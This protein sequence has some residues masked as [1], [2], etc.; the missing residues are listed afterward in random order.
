MA[1]GF[2]LVALCTL[3]SF[4]IVIALFIFWILVLVEIATKET[5]V[6]NNKLIWLLIVIFTHA[7]GALIYVIVRRPQRIQELG[8]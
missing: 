5:D 8:Q 3:L 2:G 7:L 4:G 6:N 1:A